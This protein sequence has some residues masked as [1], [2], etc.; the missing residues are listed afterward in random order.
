MRRLL[1]VKSYNMCVYSVGAQ[2]INFSS[3][4]VVLGL[5]TAAIYEHAVGSTASR[6]LNPDIGST[7][8]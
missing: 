1:P 3:F 7:Y 4:R 6:L 8:S 5:L 2:Q